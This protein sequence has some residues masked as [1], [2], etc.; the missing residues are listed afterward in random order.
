VIVE[1]VGPAGCGKSSL[2]A[3]LRAEPPFVADRRIH[4]LRAP[5]HL[6]Y[7]VSRTILSAPLL[8][9]LVLAGRR[10]SAEELKRLLYLRG[11]ERVLK[12]QARRTGGVVVVDQGAVYSLA[13]LRAFGPPALREP[14]FRGWWT[15]ACRRWGEATD[16]VVRLD[17]PLETCRARIEGRAKPHPVKGRPAAEVIEY[18][19]RYSRAFDEVLD[20]AQELGGLSVERHDTGRESLEEVAAAVRSHLLPGR[21]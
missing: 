21:S 10:P 2:A 8:L 19:E 20:L 4:D 12:R 1:I 17:A 11:W 13:T 6:P 7:A 15:E 14:R 9:R 5:R 3:A 18:L 16:L